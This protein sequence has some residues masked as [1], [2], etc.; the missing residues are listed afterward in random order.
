[1]DFSK[2]SCDSWGYC[3]IFGKTMERDPPNWQWCKNTTSEEREK[4]FNLLKKA[5]PSDNM[6]TFSIINQ[7][8]SKEE[9]F[10]YYLTLKNNQHKCN[11]ANNNQI[12]RNEK[13]IQLIEKYNHKHDFRNV[14]IACLGHNKKQFD[15]IENRYYLKKINLNDL[16]A[17]KYS[18]NEWAETRAFIAAKNLFHE[19]VDFVGFV[20]ASWNDKYE[21]FSRID[22]FHNWNNAKILLNSK[23]EDKIILCSDIFCACWWHSNKYHSSSILSSFFG[24]ASYSIGNTLLKLAKLNNF[25]HIKVPFANQMIAHRY[26]IQQYLD[27]LEND[28]ILDKVDW[29]VKKFAIKYIDNSSK[30]K[31]LYQNHRIQ[32]YLMEMISCFWFAN[33]DFV[34]IPNAQRKLSWYEKSNIEKRIEDFK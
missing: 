2:C 6:D 23:P 13:I 11:I 27:Y 19:D 1:M 33:Q 14:E 21:S 22:N 17:G 9:V 26:I 16:D 15:R 34:Y 31:N 25:N 3:P 12:K 10:L 29:F 7:A 20:T 8:K 30:I 18:G 28:N 5:P 4:Y 24:D 32:A